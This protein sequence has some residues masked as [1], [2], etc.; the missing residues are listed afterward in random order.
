MKIALIGTFPPPIGGTSVHIM[1]LRHSLVKRGYHV[2]V[3]DTS[4]TGKADFS[5]FISVTNYKKWIIKY[6]FFMNE[7][8]I[9]SHTHEWKERAVL[10]VA[11]RLHGRKSVF[12]FHSLRD[13]PKSFSVLVRLCIRIT[14]LLADRLICS[15]DTISEKLLSW[16]CPEEKLT[17]IRPFIHPTESEMNQEPPLDFQAFRKL[18]KYLLIAN[19]SNNDHYNGYDLYGLDMC[20]NLTYWLKAKGI[21]AGFVFALSKITDFAYFEEMKG[22]IAKFG[23][24]KEFLI[25]N[26]NVSLIPMLKYSDIFLRPTNTD[27]WSLSVSESL[28]LGIPAIASDACTREKGSILF[29]VRDQVDLNAKTLD[30][31]ENLEEA[32]RKIAAITIHDESEKVRKLYAKL[33]KKG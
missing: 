8:I 18:H 3:Y 31:I 24:G 14:F 2:D 12:T 4:G 33:M 27:A 16:G 32:K 20:I 17:I 13:D 11:A 6:F 26:G 7:D 5:N 30:C 9:H 29:K 10:S 28:L 23:I 19:A 25:I 21:D 22:A 15:S 1:R